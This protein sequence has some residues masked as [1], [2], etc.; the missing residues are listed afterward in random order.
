MPKHPLSYYQKR[1][2]Q[3]GQLYLSGLRVSQLAKLFQLTERRIREILHLK[4]YWRK[5]R[6]KRTPS[7]ILADLGLDKEQ[8]IT[9]IV[10]YH[11]SERPLPCSAFYS[12]LSCRSYYTQP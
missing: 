6:K 9:E 12:S 5:K 11:N 8:V 2:A 4:G 7:Q 3:I 10:R 1:D